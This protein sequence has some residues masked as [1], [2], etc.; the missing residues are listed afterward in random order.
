MKKNP[1][2]DAINEALVVNC[3]D[4]IH[5]NETAEQA[6]MRLIEWEIKIALDP[7]V[8]S[9][10]HALVEQGRKHAEMGWREKQKAEEEGAY[11]QCRFVEAWRGK[12]S[13]KVVGEHGM[14][15]KHAPLVCC[16][17]KAQATHSCEE[18]GQFVCGSPLCDDCTH[19]T[20]P[21]G[22]NG[23]VGF[24]AQSL[25][26][27]QKRHIKKSENTQLPRYA[28]RPQDDEASEG[29]DQDAP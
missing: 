22:T 20:F 13:Q 1:W 6:L 19:R 5:P 18:T 28:R 10:A 7:T 2:K 4:C 15:A 29:E 25:P 27:G 11:L 17:C 3:L 16:S 21:D 24:N 14:C 9:E 12:C 8:S 26:E 23:G